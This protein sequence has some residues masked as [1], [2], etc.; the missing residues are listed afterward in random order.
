MCKLYK[1]GVHTQ[2]L[3]LQEQEARVDQLE[4]LGEVVELRML[5]SS[6]TTSCVSTYVVKDDQLVRPSTLVVA[7]SEEKP[8]PR[9]NGDQLLRE[10]RKESPADGREV[11]VVHLEQ[12]VELEWLAV[13]HQLPSAKDDNVVCKKCDGACLERRER[14]LAGD[15]AEVLRLVANNWLESCL[16]DGPQLE[17]EGAVERRDAIVDPRGET[18]DV[19]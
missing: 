1:F 7:N 17:A 15:E 2:R 5:A 9:E 4:E 13:A 12:E 3:L 18:H 16:E 11:K 8:L 6:P 14:G 10:E 19:R